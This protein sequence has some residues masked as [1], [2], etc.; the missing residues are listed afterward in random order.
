MLLLLALDWRTGI[1][2]SLLRS[3]STVARSANV[4]TASGWHHRR[5]CRAAATLGA[6]G[7]GGGPRLPWRI[8]N[9]RKWA[10]CLQVCHED[11]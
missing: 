1:V 7:E 10:R 8:S 5:S 9:A 4:L 6:G 11:R 2:R 3:L